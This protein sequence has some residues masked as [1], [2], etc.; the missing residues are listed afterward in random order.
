MPYFATSTACCKNM[1]N[2]FINVRNNQSPNCILIIYYNRNVN[3]ID[4][5]IGIQAMVHL[6][7]GALFMETSLIIFKECVIYVWNCRLD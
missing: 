6:S 5:Q 2:S 1:I 7:E 4:Y 3:D